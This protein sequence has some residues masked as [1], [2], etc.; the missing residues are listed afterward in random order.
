MQL[1]VS[2][3]QRICSKLVARRQLQDQLLSQHLVRA[4][5]FHNWTT[6]SNSKLC[7]KWQLCSSNSSLER[8]HQRVTPTS[9]KELEYHLKWCSKLRQPLLSSNNTS[10]ELSQ[11]TLRKLSNPVWWTQIAFKATTEI[12]WH[13]SSVRLS[14]HLCQVKI[15]EFLWI[16]DREL[17]L[18]P[19]PQES[20]KSLFSQRGALCQLLRN[21]RPHLCLKGPSHRLLRSLWP[22]KIHHLEPWSRDS[23]KMSSKNSSIKILVLGPILKMYQLLPHQLTSKCL[24]W[25]A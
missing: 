1:E 18:L 9:M 17:D 10:R 7:S 13:R 16:R 24:A 5:E 21:T 8:C 23:S 22:F 25:L 6:V 2:N 3:P 4:K 20:S 11:I 15:R 12:Q 19:Q 14:V